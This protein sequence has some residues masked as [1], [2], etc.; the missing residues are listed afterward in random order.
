MLATA[1]MPSLSTE[2]K[3]VDVGALFVLLFSVD[4]GLSLTC[5]SGRKCVTGTYCVSDSGVVVDITTI[6]ATVPLTVEP[7]IVDVVVGVV[8]AVVVAAVE[9]VSA[10]VSMADFSIEDPVVDAI[11]DVTVS[12]IVAG[13]TVDVV[14]EAVGADASVVN[15]TIGV[16]VRTM[17]GEVVDTA[18]VSVCTAALIVVG[19]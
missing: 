13:A 9:A 18:A 6:F 3:T 12:T 17:V 14:D 10:A 8:A 1:D 7:V 16:A 5:N 11:V 4:S 15:E 2:S 19:G